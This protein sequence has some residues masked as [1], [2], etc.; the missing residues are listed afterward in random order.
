M[1]KHTENATG[2]R[3]EEKTRNRKVLKSKR[4]HTEQPQIRK[5]A[6]SQVKSPELKNSEVKSFTVETKVS[7]P[8]ANTERTQTGGDPNTVV[9]KFQG[10]GDV[11]GTIEFTKTNPDATKSKSRRDLTRTIQT[12]GFKSRS[13]PPKAVS[14]FKSHSSGLKPGSKSAGSPGKKKTGRKSGKKVPAG[15]SKAPTEAVKRPGTSPQA[16]IS[17]YRSLRAKDP[18]VRQAVLH[19]SFVTSPQNRAQGL[20]IAGLRNMLIGVVVF[21]IIFTLFLCGLAI[22][23]KFPFQVLRYIDS[24]EL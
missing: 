15:R 17:L 13:E 8:E 4:K 20:Q 3:K 21:A 16:R 12:D 9:S 14:T 23:K 18:I 11:K 22:A 1:A 7:S 5:D 2:T 10:P 6:V 24:P 19:H